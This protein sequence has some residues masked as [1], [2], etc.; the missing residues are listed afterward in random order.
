MAPFSRWM[1]RQRPAR[2]VAS[3][4]SPRRAFICSQR[5]IHRPGDRPVALRLREDLLG[6]PDRRADRGRP[7]GEDRPQPRVDAACSSTSPALRACTKAELELPLGVP[8]LSSGEAAPPRSSCQ[9]LRESAFIAVRLEHLERVGRP[10]AR[11]VG[12]IA[13]SSAVTHRLITACIRIRSSP[14]AAARSIASSK[15]ALATVPV[16]GLDERRPEVR[17]DREP[18]GSSGPATRTPARGG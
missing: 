10:R 17:E 8:E 9:A 4:N 6:T 12:E 7:S 3:A 13:T 16:T 5:V 11:G 2:R 18:R 1:S 15:M 14:A